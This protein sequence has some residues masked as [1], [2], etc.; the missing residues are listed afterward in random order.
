M[1]AFNAIAFGMGAIAIEAAQ[2]FYKR[3][4]KDV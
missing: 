4:G 3:G 1:E 2:E